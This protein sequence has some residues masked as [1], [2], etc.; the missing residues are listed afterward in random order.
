MKKDNPKGAVLVTGASRGIGAAI[1][2]ELADAGFPI[3]VNYHASAELAAEVVRDIRSSGGRGECFQ[4]DVSDPAAVELM[5]GFAIDKFGTIFGAVNN[6]CPPVAATG[7]ADLCWDQVQEHLDV[8]VRGAFLVCKTIMPV[9]IENA[10]GVIVNIASI[11]VDVVPPPLW[12]A[13][14]VSKSALVAMSRCLAAEHGSK[15]IRV[16]CVSPG[17]TETDLT[18]FIP[19][20]TKRTV[21]LQAPLQRLAEPVDTARAVAFLF[22]DGAAYITGETIRVAG[23]QVM[24]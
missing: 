10:S 20:V 21:E 24:R 19:D 14:T 7:F 11:C 1:A 3:I 8:Q 6:A 12:M 15:R 23:G 22:G 18:T 9:L 5:V 13:Y 16:N 4:A 17:M 2:R